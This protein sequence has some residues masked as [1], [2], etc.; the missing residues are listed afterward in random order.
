MIKNEDSLQ[1]LLDTGKAQ[2]L[3]ANIT[4]PDIQALALRAQE[5][6]AILCNGAALPIIDGK[7]CLGFFAEGSPSK[8]KSVLDSSVIV[9]EEISDHLVIG[10]SVNYYHFLF[11][12]LPCLALLRLQGAPTSLAIGAMPKTLET[13]L[14]KLLPI[15]INGHGV[16]VRI[17]PPGTYNVRNVVFPLLPRPP[18]PVYFSRNVILPIA[19]RL[20]GISD[21]IKEQGPI[22]IFVKREDHLNGRNLINQ[23]DIEDW[24]VARGYISI[25]PGALTFEEQV[26][27]FSRATHIAGVEG[28]AM[29]NI[30]F[31]PDNVDVTMI[32]SPAIKG[33]RFFEI[34]AKY[35]GFAFRT[36]YGVIPASSRKSRSANFE[37]LTLPYA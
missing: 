7:T 36:V 21:A 9:T 6:Q 26:I 28:G 25:N 18:L 4:S 23:A 33:E 30:L 35:R 29:T 20:A 3:T 22:K 37:L 5:G 10:G 12:H 16:P 24:F 31:A 2:L 17:T 27:L 1:P 19:L 8:Y 34:I 13:F 15:I 14:P 11:S 32:A